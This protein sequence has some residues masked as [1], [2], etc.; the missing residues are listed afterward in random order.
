MCPVGRSLAARAT[1]WTSD[2][3][4]I[5]AFR[6]TALPWGLTADAAMIPNHIPWASG[7]ECA[8]ALAQTGSAYHA[9]HPLVSHVKVSLSWAI[10]M[11]DRLDRFKVVHYTGHSLGG[12][13]ANSVAE[14][15]RKVPTTA[16]VFNAPGGV[17]KFIEVDKEFITGQ[18]DKGFW[19]DVFVPL[20]VTPEKEKH[21]FRGMTIHITNNDRIG[22]LGGDDLNRRSLILRDGS[23]EHSIASLIKD[24]NKLK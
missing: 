4:A 18:K 10:E 21:T 11:L 13:T 5:F 23:G 8:A 19:S 7:A 15:V 2:D 1:L 17:Q 3:E 22:R 14:L 9:S 20:F 6:G 16:V 12:F 24:L